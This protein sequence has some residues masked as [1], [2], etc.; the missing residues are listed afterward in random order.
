MLYFFLSYII[1]HNYMGGN[2]SKNSES[3]INWDKIHTV[4]MS[5][6]NKF[7]LSGDAMELIT[8]LNIPN[9]IDTESEVQNK[10]TSN[11]INKNVSVN[12]NTNE[13]SPFI[14]SDMYKQFIDT[15][16]NISDI[17]NIQKGGN[18][19]EDSSTSS[20]SE[21]SDSALNLDSE[22]EKPKKY[23]KSSY[24]KPEYKK[25]SYKKPGYKKSE[26]KK[27]EYKKPTN[28]KYKKSS[29]EE[30]SDEGSDSGSG[31][32]SGEGSVMSRGDLSYISSSAHEY[33]EESVTDEMGHN[34]ISINTSDINMISD[35]NLN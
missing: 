16:S 35:H 2:N 15:S 25:S 21:L 6:T 17:R 7:K 1:L 10:Y 23:K 13:L 3:T 8:N 30:Q 19:D 26:Y 9:I 22:D 27:S 24:K 32:E 12:Y 34:Q 29:E 4:D 28:K 33:E 11:I 20:T 18:L 14:T 31:E 5:A